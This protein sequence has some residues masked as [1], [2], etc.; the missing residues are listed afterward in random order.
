MD[1]AVIERA[2]R[3]FEEIGALRTMVPQSPREM[4]E[5]G[6]FAPANPVK[7]GSGPGERRSLWL[8]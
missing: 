7:T 5:P 3:A 1:K 4:P 6:N 8:A 2:L